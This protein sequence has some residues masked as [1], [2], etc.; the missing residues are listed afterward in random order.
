MAKLAP[1][2]LIRVTHVDAAEGVETIEQEKFVREMPVDFM[3]GYRIGRVLA[4][5]QVPRVLN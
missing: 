4:G 3:Q 1:E 5:E 2:R